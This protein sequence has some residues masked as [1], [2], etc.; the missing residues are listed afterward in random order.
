[1]YEI[2]KHTVLNF[3]TSQSKLFQL[4]PISAEDL[5]KILLRLLL[6]YFRIHYYYSTF[7]NIGK[8]E[9]FSNSIKK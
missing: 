4:Y 7:L 8:G 2:D 1:M 5:S 9:D 3:L 6:L